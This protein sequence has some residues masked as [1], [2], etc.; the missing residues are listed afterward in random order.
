MNQPFKPAFPPSIGS[1]PGGHALTGERGMSLRDWFATFAPE[2][3]EEDYKF[4]FE[5]DR[6]KD[7]HN[8]RGQRRDRKQIRAQFKFSHADAMIIEG[9]K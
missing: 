8:D 1:T 2:P 4:A 6:I 9:Q 3:S 5:Q 7:P